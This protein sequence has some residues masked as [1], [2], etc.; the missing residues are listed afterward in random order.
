MTYK[1]IV[2]A[3]AEQHVL[4]ACLHYE[5][6][7]AGLSDKFLYELRVAYDKIASHPEYYG[8]IS[9]KDK[10]RDIR[11]HKFPFVVIYEV[12]HDAVVVMAVFNTNRKP[13]T[14][15]I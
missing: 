15:L 3:T 2:T 7:L 13:I 1:V 14:W 10:F 4:D 9:P 6:Q 12:L 5:D 11:I 8:F